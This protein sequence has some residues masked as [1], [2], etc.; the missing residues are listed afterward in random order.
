MTV[1]SCVNFCVQGGF[2]FAGLEFSQVCM[3]LLIGRQKLLYTHTNGF[4]F[5]NVTVGIILSTAVRM[6]PP[7]T[8]MP[9]VKVTR[10]KNVVVT[11]SS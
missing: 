4:T 8:V 1:E 2:I 10:P 7:L 5:R 6:R 11:V 3:R 9:H